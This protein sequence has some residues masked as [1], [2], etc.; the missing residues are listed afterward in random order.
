MQFSTM[1]TAPSTMM[2]KSSAPRLIRLPL[3][4]RSTMP[5]MVKSI[6]SGMTHAVMSAA[7]M[8]PR[9]QNRIDDHQQ[10][11]DHEVVLDGLDGARRPASVRS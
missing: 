7:R 6:E 9:K 2:P 4:P 1:M 8:L 3:T 10:R 11:A 5:V